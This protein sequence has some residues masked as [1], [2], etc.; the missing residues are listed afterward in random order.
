MKKTKNIHMGATPKHPLTQIL[1]GLAKAKN[2]PVNDLMWMLA[3]KLGVKHKQTIYDWSR[4]AV[5][6]VGSG[7]QQLKPWMATAL[8]AATDDFCRRGEVNP[9]RAYLTKLDEKGRRKSAAVK[10]R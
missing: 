6:G 2:I 1:H 8:M 9:V 5:S 4:K 7:K 3:D 10:R